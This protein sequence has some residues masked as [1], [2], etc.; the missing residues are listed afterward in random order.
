MSVLYDDFLLTYTV[1]QWDMMFGQQC[2]ISVVEQCRETVSFSIKFIIKGAGN[3]MTQPFGET[4]IPSTNNTSKLNI[5]FVR[6]T[7]FIGKIIIL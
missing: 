2:S 1:Y 6:F 5:Y 4:P 3:T 7:S